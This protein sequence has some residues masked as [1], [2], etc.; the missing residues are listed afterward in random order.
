MLIS[1][2]GKEEQWRIIRQGTGEEGAC[3][4]IPELVS[5]STIQV[6]F[7]FATIRWLDWGSIKHTTVAAGREILTW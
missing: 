1:G 4:V 5:G 6:G 3:T 7:F 2:V